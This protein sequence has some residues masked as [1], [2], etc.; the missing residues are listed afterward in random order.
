MIESE[1]SILVSFLLQK[2]APFP[3]FFT[4]GGIV[5]CCNDVHSK[6][7]SSPIKVRFGGILIKAFFLN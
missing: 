7:D 5:I 1:S 2:K 4:D 6:K 3:I